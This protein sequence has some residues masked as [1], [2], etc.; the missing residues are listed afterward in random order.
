MRS[1][2]QKKGEKYVRDWRQ[3]EFPVLEQFHW[4]RVVF[5]EFHELES[6]DSLQQNS[7]QHLRSSYRWGLTGTPPVDCNAGVIFMS[8]LFRIDL[9]GYIERGPGQVPN[10]SSWEGDRWLTQTAGRFLDA[11]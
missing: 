7:L 5:D 3:L 8:S 9:P 11:S 1:G 10:L 4:R 6:F 2:S